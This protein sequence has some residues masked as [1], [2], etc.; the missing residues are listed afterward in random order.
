MLTDQSATAGNNSYTSSPMIQSQSFVPNSRVTVADTP[1]SAMSMSTAGNQLDRSSFMPSSMH[2]DMGQSSLLPGFNQYPG[3][4]NRNAPASNFKEVQRPFPQAAS[5]TR[6]GRDRSQSSPGPYLSQ[7]PIGF[8]AANY[9]AYENQHFH[10]SNHAAYS[11]QSYSSSNFNNFGP[12]QRTHQE[13][14]GLLSS[15]MHIRREAQESSYMSAP[16][17]AAPHATS[18]LS[19]R[20]GMSPSRSQP[21]VAPSRMPDH[22]RPGQAIE[23]R[24]IIG[25]SNH[26]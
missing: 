17:A 25:S 10:Q 4:S 1:L 7:A 20:D 11:G 23:G 3:Q 12:P 18:F 6:D 9:H 15:G 16:L 19:G 26:S 24:G 5:P 8:N 21:N 22:G 13:N 2:S 14:P